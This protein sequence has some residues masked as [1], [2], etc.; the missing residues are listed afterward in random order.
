MVEPGSQSGTWRLGWRLLRLGSA[1]I[2]RLDERQAALPVMERIH[3]AT[4]ETV[5]LCVRR[6]DEAV[7]IERHR[8]APRAVARAAPRRLAAA[9]RRRGSADAARVG[10]ARGVGGLRREG[11]PDSTGTPTAPRSTQAELFAELER[12]ARTG[13]RDERRGHH[14]R[15]S[16]RSGAPIFDYSGRDPGRDLDRRHAPG[17]A[18]GHAR[19]GDPAARRRRAGRSRSRSAT[20]AST[21]SSRPLL[22][23]GL[24]RPRRRRPSRRSAAERSIASQTRCTRRPVAR[25][26]SQLP[27]GQRVE[28]IG[29]LVDEARPV[30]DALADR[31]PVAGVRM[32]GVLGPDPVEPVEPGVSRLRRRTTARSA[33]GTRSAACRACR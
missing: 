2:E 9:A 17:A 19:G 7:C 12:D 5:F 27:S 23:P 22:K 24:G 33:A 3:E 18:R 14:A 4:E 30:A 15:A 20:R 8:R 32:R 1:V 31:P 16:A 26:G 6:G 28:V 21:A 10:A 11:P 25:S 13:L 29:R